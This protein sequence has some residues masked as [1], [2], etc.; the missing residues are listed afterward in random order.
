MGSHWENKFKRQAF[1]EL[2]ENLSV[3]G[4]I[5]PMAPHGPHVECS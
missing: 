1:K 4:L 3:L 2:F 5:F